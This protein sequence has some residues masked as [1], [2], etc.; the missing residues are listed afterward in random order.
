MIKSYNLL[1]KTY[2][3]ADTDIEFVE[4]LF[5]VSTLANSGTTELWMKYFA[6]TMKETMGVEI[7]SLQPELFVKDLQLFGILKTELA[8]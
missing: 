4:K 2:V 5:K 7:S 6:D 1:N 3:F 8:N